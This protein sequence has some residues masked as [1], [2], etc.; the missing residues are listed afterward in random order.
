[1]CRSVR[2]AARYADVISGPTNSDPT[3]LPKPEAYEP[4]LVSGAAV[5]ALRGRRAAWSS[6][7]GH[8]ICDPEVERVTEAA[9]RRLCAAAGLELVDVAV[10][11]PNPARA[12]G[13]LG[14]VGSAMRHK[15]R[16]EG[17]LDE[18]T[19]VVRAGLRFAERMTIDDLTRALQRRNDMLAAIGRVFDEVDYLLTPTTAT[20]AF[21]AQGP[22]PMEIAGRQVGGMGNVPYTAPF[23][24]SG[25][26]AVSIP[27]ELSGEGLPIG[28][29]VVGRRH[30]EIGV[31]AA[32]LVAERSMPWPKFA[33][34][35]YRS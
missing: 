22:P 29:Q 24:M 12:W 10:E 20:T 3:S 19:P 34:M 2:D 4:Q 9:A 6:T 31:L 11:L 5:A 21:A 28:L 8:A 25:Q 23:N 30:D 7:L 33:P 14:S 35:A 15:A 26:P 16:A 1:M 13:I 27:C 18:L 17:R 32:G